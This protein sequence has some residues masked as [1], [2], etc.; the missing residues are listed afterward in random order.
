MKKAVIAISVL[1]FIS[2]SAASAHAD[3]DS[4]LAGLNLQA[5]GDMEGFSVKLSNQF[6]VSLPRVETIITRVEEPADAFMCLQLGAMAKEEPERVV[7]T[8]RR[9]KE[10]GWGAVA[11]DLGIKPGSAEFHA[12]KRG[13][14]ELTGE[15]GMAT[16]TKETKGKGK[17]KGKSK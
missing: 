11:K 9:K 17:G 10:K 5:R 14:F 8:Y 3:L 15:G 12:L 4:F 7:Q 2:L 6:G 13:D 16:D 1:F